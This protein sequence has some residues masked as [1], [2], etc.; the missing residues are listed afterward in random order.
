L[1]CYEIRLLLKDYQLKT[2][3]LEAPMVGSSYNA[4]PPAQGDRVKARWVPMRSGGHATKR[5]RLAATTSSA[6][7]LTTSG[8]VVMALVRTP[9]KLDGIVPGPAGR[10]FRAACDL[11]DANR[12]EL[13][14]ASG[15]SGKFVAAYC[16]DLP[17]G[18]RARIY[19]AAPAAKDD[20][21]SIGIGTLALE[22]AARRLSALGAWVV[23]G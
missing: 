8:A 14:I 22:P 4:Q 15:Q 20:L 18:W 6:V 12:S 10:G 16:R 2:L 23:V 9:P 7:V 5:F 19:I 13:M 3:Y 17:A 1:V 21:L 11:S